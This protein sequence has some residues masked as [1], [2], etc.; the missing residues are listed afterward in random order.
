LKKIEANIHLHK[1]DSVKD[2]LLSAGVI[3]MTISEIR[4]FGRNKNEARVYRGS[5]YVADFSSR[6]KVEAIVEDALVDTVVQELAAA[7]RTGELGD[8]KIFVSSIEETIRIRT[9]EKGTE[10]L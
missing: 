7:A 2:N 5:E 8:G 3:G 10:A 4:I 6:I 9:E 1:L